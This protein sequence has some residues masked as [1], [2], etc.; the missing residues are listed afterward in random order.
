MLHLCHI[1]FLLKNEANPGGT[2]LVIFFIKKKIG[3]QIRVEEFSSLGGGWDLGCM[4][5]PSIPSQPIEP[6]SL[7]IFLLEVLLSLISL[8]DYE[9]AC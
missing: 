4:T 3:A 1:I 5:T 6:G 9:S 2:D 7:I 8:V